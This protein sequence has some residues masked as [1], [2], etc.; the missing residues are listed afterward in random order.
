MINLETPPKFAPLIAQ[1]RHVA[2]EIF[3]ANSRK[4]DRA[5]HAYPR[6]LDMLAA[7][8]EGLSDGGALDGA[9]A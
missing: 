8:I 2:T 3:R 4:Y 1:A 6:E 7:M 5:E 9:G